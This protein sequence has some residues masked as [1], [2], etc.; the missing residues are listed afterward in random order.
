MPGDKDDDDFWGSLT[1]DDD[2]GRASRTSPDTTTDSSPVMKRREAPVASLDTERPTPT[3]RRPG[4]WSWSIRVGVAALIGYGLG[5]I[6]PTPEGIELSRDEVADAVRIE[7]HAA[8]QTFV[9][10]NA[11][12]LSADELNEVINDLVEASRAAEGADAGG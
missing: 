11:N 4:R 10:D 6:T 3:K 8:D 12:D 9:I 5:L 2:A 7:I 1:D